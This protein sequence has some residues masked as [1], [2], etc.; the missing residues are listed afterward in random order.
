VGR[1]QIMAFNHKL[2]DT[3]TWKRYIAEMFVSE[4]NTSTPCVQFLKGRKLDA[5]CAEP[6]RVDFAPALQR[7]HLRRQH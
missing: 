4:E 5:R 1:F 6:P 3:P 2:P 7:G